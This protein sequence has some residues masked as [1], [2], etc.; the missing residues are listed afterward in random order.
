MAP[1]SLTSGLRDSGLTNNVMPRTTTNPIPAYNC[2]RGRLLASLHGGIRDG[3]TCWKV[4][5]R[6]NFARP[7]LVEIRDV[8]RKSRFAC[9]VPGREVRV[10]G[11]DRGQSGRNAASRKA[12]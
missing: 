8:Q 3:L 6:F 2:Q 9:L 1:S 12:S 5:V 7:R 10:R 11:G 4:S